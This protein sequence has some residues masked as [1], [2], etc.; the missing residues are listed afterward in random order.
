MSRNL[1]RM[2]IALVISVTCSAV[3]WKFFGDKQQTGSGQKNPVADLSEG[4][5]EV[6]RKPL[7]RVIWENISKDEVLYPGEAVRTASNAEAKILLRKN[8]ATI[9][10]EPDSLVVLEESD[11]GLSLDFLQ[12][13]MMVAGG[14]GDLTVK[15]GSGEIKLN[16]ADMSLSKDK[17]GE[18][19]LEVLKGQAELQQGG[20]KV[21]LE[22]DKA[23]TL[24]AKGVSVAKE[25]L[26]ILSP[27]A[28]ESVLL[29]LIKGEKATVNWTPLP[30]GYRISVD[31]GKSRSNFT[32]T[33]LASA[34]GETG[35]ATFAA[36]P[37]KWFLRLNAEA[38][39]PKLPKLAPAIVPFVV[40]AKTPP[41]LLEPSEN[42]ALL[43]KDSDDPI[44]FAWT[45]RHSY[46]SQVLE[47]ASDPLF[48]QVKIKQ[49][50]AGTATAT[51]GVLPDGFFYWRVTGFLQVKDKA[52]ALSSNAL[53]FGLSSN[54]E[55]KPPRLLSPV[56]Q[57]RLSYMDVQ[58][59]SGV[60]L[61]WQASPGVRRFH[62]TV[63]KQTSAGIVTILDQTGETSLAKVID[64]VPGTYLWKVAA[65]DPKDDAEKLSEVYEFTI[66]ELP[67][68]EWVETNPD[69]IFEFATPTPSLRAEWKPLTPQPANYRY[70]VVADGQPI[71][72]GRWLTTKQTLFDI[73]LPQEGRY[74]ASVE[75]LNS[76][77]QA[78]AATDVRTFTIRAQPLLPAP[79][80]AE[81]APDTFKSDA[82]GNLSFT[83]EQVD[84]AKNYMMI[85]ESE[86]G[87]VL[88]QRAVQR[89][90]A[91]LARLKPGQYQVKLKSVDINQRPG[92]I[93]EAKRI[94]VPN[95]SDIRAPKIKTMKVK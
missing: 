3:T 93:G 18:V 36:K 10:L 83:W 27:K 56:H 14:N 80:W 86:E 70:R 85:L 71:Q 91:S 51:T 16:S 47:V 30:A 61:K 9:H 92:P 52:E 64:P 11:K 32:R 34:G 60:N 21:S 38:T 46:Q 1:R 43:R 49:A 48:K 31:T 90:T 37:G 88:E 55:V 7:R 13:N 4:V 59:N 65:I 95:V 74:Q 33:G 89:N 94:S 22:K 44:T 24:S 5:N 23:A 62:V 29:N 28:N 84:G 75:A 81:G 72:D 39:D 15:T 54:W 63:T 66:D 17:S 69:H 2:L 68:L 77:G 20:Q 40:E 57:Q 58:R 50:L 41:A 26:Q 19:N 35:T 6:Q 82:K 87:Q 78:I 73:S 42:A 45:N 79:K 25:R 12:G 76:R 8:G 53:P 67:A